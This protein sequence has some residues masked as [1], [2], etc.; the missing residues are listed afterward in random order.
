[1]SEFNSKGPS[2][3]MV[4]VVMPAYNVEKFLAQ[5]VIS[6]IQQ[7]LKDIEI[8]L[9]D[10]G[11]HDN[12]GKII[13]SFASADS[14]IV[15][16]HQKNGGYGKAVNAGLKVA[17]GKYIAIIE[18]DDWI[19]S[20][21]LQ[22]LVEKAEASGAPI[23]KGSFIKH[24]SDGR[25]YPCRL[26]HIT[27]GPERELI[28]NQSL[29]LIIYES[30]IWSAIYRRDFLLKNDIWMPETAGAAYQ[31]VVWK[32]C[33]YACADKIELIDEPV[34]NYRVMAPGSSSAAA[35][36]EKAMFQN[37]ELIKAFLESRGL[38]NNFKESFYFHQFFDFVFHTKRLAANPEVYACFLTDARAVIVEAETLG[39]DFTAARFHPDVNDYVQREVM[40]LFRELRSPF[41]A[42]HPNETAPSPTQTRQKRRSWLKSSFR[43]F[44][45]GLFKR[46]FERI[47]MRPISGML[48]AHIGRQHDTVQA[49][50]A[51][52]ISAVNARIA[53]VENALVAIDRVVATL[54]ADISNC[55]A[56]VTDLDETLRREFAAVHDSVA[57]L[58]NVCNRLTNLVAPTITVPPTAQFEYHTRAIRAELPGLIA[59]LK[60]G[61][62]E[63]SQ[64]QVDRYFR[65][66]SMLPINMNSDQRLAF[67]LIMSTFSDEERLV[68][69]NR[70][71][72]IARLM[73][74][75]ANLDMTDVPFTLTSTYY[76]S[77][78]KL[79]PYRIT[80]HFRDSV[81]LDCGASVGDS[82]IPI[83]RYGFRSV[84]C[85]EPL[86]D[87]FSLLAN[88]VAKNRLGDVIIPRQ[89]GVDRASGKRHLKRIGEMG[90]GSLISNDN[91]D[92][93]VEVT[94]IDE[95]CA[96]IG[97]SIGLIK[98][99]VEGKELD[100]L[101]GA[102]GVIRKFKPVLLCAVYHTWLQP[103]QIFS[104]KEFIEELDLGYEFQFK[105]LEPNCNVIYEHWLIA[106]C[107]PRWSLPSS[108]P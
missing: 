50:L 79:V 93:E 60:S 95:F 7:T 8:I 100:A 90:E 65:L 46:P 84:Y 20:R 44:R 59:K 83:A 54:T 58:N 23:V 105:W 107:K 64:F 53:Q 52:S 13:D 35:G 26:D 27:N 102:E 63:A 77:G 99:D 71:L 3:P 47:V 1:M 21:M 33:T 78:L 15:A 25:V 89:L 34:Y 91:A 80:E 6:V 57:K 108:V 88:T 87:V 17:R 5:C 30:S 38:F 48:E 4:S 61:M 66:F 85:F 41:K 2:M 31:D 97:A 9:I 14:R 72:L 42:P 18:T 11:S 28:P 96:S 73:E 39:V 24:E 103:D 12:S 37:Y 19:E 101:K 74:S 22:L 81:A 69:A 67:P 62:D 36:R 75:Y 56:R 86:P 45:D 92:L 40:P 43:K 49:G 106:Y 76:E 29:E 16:I 82:A 94:S 104:V 51:I 10:D 70:D 32:F 55:V 98:L 68:L